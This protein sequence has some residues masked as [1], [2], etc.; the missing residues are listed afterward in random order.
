MVVVLSLW[1][2]AVLLGG[3]SLAV[4]VV[5]VRLFGVVVDLFFGFLPF[6]SFLQ[7]L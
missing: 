7:P 6:L 2:L 4:V 5:V 3:E 1:C